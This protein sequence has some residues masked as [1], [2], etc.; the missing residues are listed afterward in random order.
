MG[1]P[2]DQRAKDIE[3]WQAQVAAKDR[4]NKWSIELAKKR[5]KEKAKKAS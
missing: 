1:W 5:Q 2:I 3:D 4:V